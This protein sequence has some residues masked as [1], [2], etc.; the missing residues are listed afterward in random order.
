MGIIDDR[1][2]Q[3][4]PDLFVKL[5]VVDLPVSVEQRDEVRSAAFPWPLR[6]RLPEEPAEEDPVGLR[7]R[8]NDRIGDVVAH[9]AEAI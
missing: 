4:G 2:L 1:P 3:T 8:P 7:Y 6:L 9:V 5:T